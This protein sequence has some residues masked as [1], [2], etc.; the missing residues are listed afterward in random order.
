MADEKCDVLIIGGGLVGLS[1]ALQLQNMR[2]RQRICLIEKECNVAMHQSGRNS[3]VAHAGIY[4]QPGSLK[5]R[6][7]VDGKIALREYC[8]SNAIPY[9]ACGKVIVATT[10]KEVRRLDYLLDRGRQNEV[11]GL[12]L[13][14]RDELNE[15]EPNVFGLKALYSPES[16]IV[17]FAAVAESIARDFVAAG[18]SLFLNTAFESAG[19]FRK[20]RHIRTSNQDFDARLT[21]N[22]AGLF[23]DVVARRMGTIPTIRIIPFR[24]DFYDLTPQSAGL[25]KALIYPVPDPALPFLGV[26]L[27]PTTDGR[28]RAGPNAILA[29]RRE[30]Y[31]PVD[32]SFREVADTLSY[33][34]FWRFSARY[35]RPGVTEINRS[36]RK[37]VF[38]K[39]VQKLLPA[40]TA[41]DLVPSRS[42]VR[43][44]AIDSKGRMVDDFCIEESPGTIHVLNAPSPA[45]TSALMIGRH[46]ASQA[47]LRIDAN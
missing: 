35:I 19:E 9:V 46:V 26:H 8:T 27:T 7:C 13:V 1:T 47:I 45:A 34:G 6:F 28:V 10:E 16:A 5:A 33:A 40:V 18:G 42:G 37:R 4:Y 2:P 38:A 39:S 32:F 21:I 41:D 44:Q 22:C 24:G 31:R 17:D 43:A 15:L 3:G 12:R 23:A 20:Q 30:G 29:T 11:A 25:V 36:L 14:E